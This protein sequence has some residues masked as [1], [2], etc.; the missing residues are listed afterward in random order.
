MTD[1]DQV[2]KTDTDAPSSETF[3]ILSIIVFFKVYI[4]DYS[5]MFILSSFP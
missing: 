2:F 1:N 3:R 4:I 5:K